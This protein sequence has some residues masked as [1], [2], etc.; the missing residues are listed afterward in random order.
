[1]CLYLSQELLDVE[2]VYW[3]NVYTELIAFADAFILSNIYDNYRLRSLTI[4]MILD[5]RELDLVRIITSERNAIF[6][7]HLLDLISGTDLSLQTYAWMSGRTVQPL[8]PDGRGT[9][10]KWM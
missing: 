1:M 5:I 9:G 8:L 10:E 3:R 7:C 4:D 6:L 2:S